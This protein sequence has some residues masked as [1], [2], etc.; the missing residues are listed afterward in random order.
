MGGNTKYIVS[1]VAV[2]RRLVK[3]VVV[4]SESVPVR[5]VITVSV[6]TDGI[7]ITV[8][9]GIERESVSE[10]VEERVLEVKLVIVESI[11]KEESVLKEE[12]IVRSVSVCVV[13]SE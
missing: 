1:S 7:V 2:R 11:L 13:G 5:T 9:V 10:V 12:S 6:V 8:S 3:G 4:V